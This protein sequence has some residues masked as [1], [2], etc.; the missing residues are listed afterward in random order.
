MLRFSFAAVLVSLL[1]VSHDLPA[2]VI[3]GLEGD[4][5]LGRAALGDGDGTVTFHSQGETAMGVG[6]ESPSAATSIRAAFAIFDLP[7]I[8][9]GHAF[10]AAEMQVTLAASLGALNG[11]AVD[12]YALALSAD[13]FF[14]RADFYAGALDVTDATLLHDNIITSTTPGGMVSSLGGSGAASTSLK[15][16]LNLQYALDPSASDKYLVLRFNPDADP[17][18]GGGGRHYL[19][20]NE[21]GAGAPRLVFETELVPEPGALSLLLLALPALSRRRR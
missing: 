5:E 8:D 14:K 21:D 6:T 1:A 10:T 17:R 4:Q 15:D 3:D 18:T 11:F 12:A 13:P 2:A 7:A 20:T 19:N 16:F 9:A